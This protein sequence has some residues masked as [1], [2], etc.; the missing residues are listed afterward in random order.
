VRRLCSDDEQ[1]ELT[2]VR[3]RSRQRFE[4]VAVA[5]HDD[6]VVMSRSSVRQSRA[7]GAPG[8][9]LDDPSVAGSAPGLA[10]LT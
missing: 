1:G 6:D 4:V 10:D 2:G 3:R 7:G 5:V 9:A 8:P